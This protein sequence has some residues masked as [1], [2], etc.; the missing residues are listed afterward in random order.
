MSSMCNLNFAI[1]IDT[2]LT[3]RQNNY[4]TGHTFMQK[5]YIFSFT[6]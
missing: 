1:K 6:L 2:P 5:L 4:K 3:F